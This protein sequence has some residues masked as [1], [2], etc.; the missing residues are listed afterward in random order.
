MENDDNVAMYFSVEPILSKDMLKNELNRA[1]FVKNLHAFHK[2]SPIMI[3]N[4]FDDDLLK[5]ILIVL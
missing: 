4:D 2:I 1:F 3:L 5:F